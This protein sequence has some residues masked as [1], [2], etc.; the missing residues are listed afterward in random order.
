MRFVPVKDE[1]QQANAVVFRARDLWCG[2]GP[3]ASTPCA[4]TWPST[5]M[6]C[7]KVPAHVGSLVALV[8]DPKASGAR[9]RA[10]GSCR[11]WPRS[12]EHAT[13]R[14]RWRGLTARPLDG[15]RLDRLRAEG[16]EGADDL[17]HVMVG[18]L[19]RHGRAGRPSGRP[20]FLACDG[21]GPGQVA[22]LLASA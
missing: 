1:A 22:Q 11:C 16:G 19:G 15:E 21:A 6:W 9:E 17:R 3:S 8:E 7:R 18:P 2:S 12:L 10:R 5:G 20:R 14:V 4:G 13:H